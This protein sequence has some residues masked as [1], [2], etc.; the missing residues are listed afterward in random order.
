M[1]LKGK[2]IAILAEDMYED[3]ELWYPYYRLV[4]EGAEVKIIGPEAKEYQSKHGYPVQADL[5]A[6]EAKAGDFQGI[7]VP[8]G[9]APD[10]LRRYPEILDI[11]R[12]IFKKGGVVASICHGPWVLISANIMNGKQTTGVISLKDDL[13]N[14]GAIY[15]DKEV[16]VDNNLQNTSRPSGIPSG[17]H[18]RSQEIK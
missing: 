8:G 14:A 6:A 15:L 13:I 12:E 18:Y 3:L 11:V 5:S 17:N 9:F 10:R 7:I 4:E 2:R 1:S 16:V